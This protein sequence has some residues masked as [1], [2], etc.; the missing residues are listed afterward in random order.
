MIKFEIEAT[1]GNSRAGILQTNDG[2]I[3]T[4]IFMPVGT[5][6]TVKAL[7]TNEVKQIGAEIVLSNTYHLHLRPGDKLIKKMGGLHQFMNW[8]GPIL[9]DSGGFQI[10]SLAKLLKLNEEGAVIR[11]HIDGSKIKLSPEISISIQQNLKSTI[12]MCLDQCIELPV[13]RIEIERSMALTKRWAERCKI[14]RDKYKSSSKQQALFGILQGGCE[15][16]LREQSLE[17]IVQIGFDGYAIGGLSVGEK[18]E[19]M[20]NITHHI[21]PKMPFEKPRYLM[22]VGRPEDLLEGIEAGIDMFDCVMPTRNARNGSLFTSTGEI[23]IKQSRYTQDSE[24]LDS[25]CKCSTCE[26]YSRAYLHHLFKSREILGIRLNT[27]H[28]LFF[29][30]TL[31]KE[32]RIAIKEQRFQNFKKSFLEKYLKE[33]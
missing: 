20:Y 29:Y 6:G 1:N 28:N 14:T 23:K 5:L 21:A 27:F 25:D 17:Q 12:M 2:K 19:E 32:A 18:K 22:G 26:N 7:T 33:T 9:T 8:H 24:P 3:N 16:D 13:S 30:I 10:F 4:P 31:V 15:L 11:S